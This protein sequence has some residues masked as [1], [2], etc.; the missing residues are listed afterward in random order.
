MPMHS[1]E[2]LLGDP[3]LQAIGFFNTVDHPTEGK[4]RTMAV[5]SR[6]SGTPPDPSRQAPRLGEH[7]VEVLREAGYDDD[8][9]ADLLRDRVTLAAA[10][11]AATSGASHD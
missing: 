5:P 8:A 2:S 10:R 3:Q 6:W 1:V 9:I 7:S 11:D 4:L